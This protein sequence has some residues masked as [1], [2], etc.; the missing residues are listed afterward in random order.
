[1]TPLAHTRVHTHDEHLGLK[2]LPPTCSRT[3][4]VMTHPSEM[5]INLSMGAL[6]ISTATTAP[7]A[8]QPQEKNGAKEILPGRRASMAEDGLT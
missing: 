5:I 2:G 6:V 8:R 4:R 1:M 7:A 3:S